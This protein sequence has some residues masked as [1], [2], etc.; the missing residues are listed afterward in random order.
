MTFGTGSTGGEYNHLIDETEAPVRCYVGT[1]RKGWAK[2]DWTTPPAGT[3]LFIMNG[4]DR[5]TRMNITQP[6]QAEY[7]WRRAS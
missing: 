3:D 2:L 1:D 5:R 4:T 7:Y 6:Y